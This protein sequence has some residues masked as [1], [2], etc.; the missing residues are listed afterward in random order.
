MLHVWRK[1]STECQTRVALSNH[2][3]SKLHK[4]QSKSL[5]PSTSWV[6][7][8]KAQN[9]LAL[10]AQDDIV[11]LVCS[12]LVSTPQVETL[13]YC[14]TTLL[15]LTPIKVFPFLCLLYY[16][17]QSGMQLKMPAMLKVTRC[18]RWHITHAFCLQGCPQFRWKK[19]KTVARRWSA[20][21]AVMV[22]SWRIPL[23]AN[24]PAHKR[25][26]RIET[27]GECKATFDGIYKSQRDVSRYDTRLRAETLYLSSGDHSCSQACIIPA[28]LPRSMKF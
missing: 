2:A 16:P 6:S 9:P 1:C 7:G 17:E 27:S 4:E 21:V 5:H 20:I 15:L 22:C 14:V 18:H 8:G 11:P 12:I 23:R 19:K 10:D 26:C 28:F 3:P 13:R 25:L 24:T